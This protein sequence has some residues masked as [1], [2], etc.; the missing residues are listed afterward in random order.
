MERKKNHLPHPKNEPLSILVPSFQCHALSNERL[1]TYGSFEN[2]FWQ[3][4]C[5]R[6]IGE[7]LFVCNLC[8]FHSLGSL[9][10]HGPEVYCASCLSLDQSRP[11]TA[12]SEDC[13]VH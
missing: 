10:K 11:A 12:V 3:C 4:L 9:G 13:G 2:N 5:P 6:T 7:S 1:L 8:T